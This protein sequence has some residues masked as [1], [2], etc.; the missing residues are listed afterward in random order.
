MKKLFSILFLAIGLSAA[1]QV[2]HYV[3]T[4]AV[5]GLADGTLAHPWK[6]MQQVQDAGNNSEV[7][8][9]DTIAFKAGQVHISPNRWG[10]MFWWATAGYTCPSGITF[11]RY[12]TGSNPNMLFPFPSAVPTGDR[13]VMSFEG[14]TDIVIDSL[15][16]KDYRF[17][18]VD[19]V[20]PAY[21]SECILLGEKGA[22][23]EVQNCWVKNCGFD[24][25]GMAVVIGGRNNV[26]YNNDMTDFRN[27]I[28]TDS[29]SVFTSTEDYGATAVTLSGSR[30][31]I[32]GNRISGAWAAS[33]DFVWN[34]G[35]IEYYGACDS[36]V[37]MYNDVKDCGGTG[38]LGAQGGAGTDS[39]KDN[40]VARN[41]FHNCGGMSYSNWNPV[42]SIVT[43]NMQY[44]NNV[45]IEDTD[46]RFSGPN[47]GTGVPDGEH[48]TA[49]SASDTWLFLYGINSP[50]ANIYTIKNNLFILSTGIKICGTSSKYLHD[51]NVV[52]LAGSSTTGWTA[53]T[54]DV[55]TSAALFQDETNGDASL[56]DFHPLADGP[57]INT[58]VDVSAR[59]LAVFTANQDKDGNEVADPPEIGLFEL[60]DVVIP[61]PP[62]GHRFYIK[63]NFVKKLLLNL[64]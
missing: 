9:G 58:G 39:A 10:G 38:E 61:D 6:T 44:L 20:T 53:G 25:I 36:N 64:H 14:V 35:V 54:G 1:G 23:T 24:R 37:V 59:I 50:A 4:S 28:S 19:K 63:S 29:T 27:V 2:K 8:P 62:T 55:T 16:F 48:Q 11:T 43:K 52:R 3:D 13:I 18:A 56:W 21:T 17:P 51:H 47:T 46:S 5:A 34:G 15:D 40:L 45:I 42:F 49:A 33:R 57:L 41:I 26:V 32:I 30:N 7:D 12:G 60:Q 22:A 31:W